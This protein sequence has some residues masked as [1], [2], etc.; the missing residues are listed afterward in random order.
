MKYVVELDKE[1]AQSM[2]N[3]SDGSDIIPVYGH[4]SGERKVIGKATLKKDEHRNFIANIELDP[5]LEQVKELIKIMDDSMLKN[6]GLGGVVISEKSP[7]VINKFKLTEVSII[8][9]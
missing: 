9:K 6:V 5:K 3:K 8:N 4:A 1:I 2:V 7:N